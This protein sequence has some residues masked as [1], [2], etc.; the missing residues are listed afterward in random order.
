MKKEDTL[1]ILLSI[2]LVFAIIGLAYELISTESG[3]RRSSTLATEST[4]VIPYYYGLVWSTE[5]ESGIDFGAIESLPVVEQNAVS[6]YNTLDQTDYYV[7]VS[8]YSNTPVDF[9]LMADGPLTLTG[10]PSVFIPLSDY[11]WS[12]S[13]SNNL[14]YP[15]KPG[16]AIATSYATS[17]DTEDIQ[18]GEDLNFRFWLSVGSSQEAGEYTNQISFQGVKHGEP[19]V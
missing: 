7:S 2:V 13:T 12:A 19:C 11:V 14:N 1:L 5:L 9:C 15:A 17:A 4:A 16:V 6:N 8:Q 10:V 18:P 3:L